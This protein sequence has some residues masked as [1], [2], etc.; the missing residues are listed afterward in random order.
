MPDGPVATGRVRRGV[1]ELRRMD[2]TLFGGARR[3]GREGWEK[4]PLW[5]PAAL[6]L[7]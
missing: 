6:G 5:P 1:K 2:W 4:D 7:G 3:K